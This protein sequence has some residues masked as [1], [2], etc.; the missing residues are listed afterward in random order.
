MFTVLHD[1]HLT[2]TDLKPENIL[3]VNSDADVIFDT[4][5]VVT[6]PSVGDAVVVIDML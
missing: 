2:H 3:F 5:K 4:Q 1:N 6:R